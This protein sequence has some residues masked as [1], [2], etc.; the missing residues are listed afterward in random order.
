MKKINNWSRIGIKQ[1]YVSPISGFLWLIMPR[2][3]IVEMIWHDYFFPSTLN[4]KSNLINADL[5]LNVNYQVNVMDYFITWKKLHYSKYN[6]YSYAVTY[7]G[8]VSVI[9][10]HLDDTPA[11]IN[12]YNYICVWG[13]CACACMRTHIYTN[14]VN[15]WKHKITFNY[16]FIH[17]FS[18]NFLVYRLSVLIIYYNIIYD[19]IWYDMIWL[20]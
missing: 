4:E 14:W 18:I 20:I 8:T 10:L 13:V 12:M 11:I 1:Q 15:F 5:M 6:A 17:S 16:I 3:F 19:M 9:T 2:N 7:S